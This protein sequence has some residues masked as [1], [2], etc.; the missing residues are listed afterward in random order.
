MTGQKTIEELVRRIRMGEDSLLEL[1]E[2]RFKGGRIDAPD[3]RQIADELSAM[4]YRQM[5]L[6]L[7]PMC[8][9]MPKEIMFIY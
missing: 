4:A 6:K 1:K 7:S 3:S 8:W 2:V 5:C 9:K